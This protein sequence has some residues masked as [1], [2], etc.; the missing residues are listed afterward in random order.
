MF[1]PH[2][3]GACIEAALTRAE[4][5]CRT[6]GL[7]LTPLRRRVLEILLAGHRAMGAYAVLE[8]LG[9]DG[10]GAAQP[11]VAYRALDFLVAHGLA[12][13][14]E[15]LN[16]YVACSHGAAS[17]AGAAGGGTG[18]G[19]GRGGMAHA[20]V[21][22]ICQACGA[23]AETAWQPRRSVL[24]RAARAAGFRLEQVLSEALGTCPA[25]QEGG[26]GRAHGKAER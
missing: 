26:A 8:A 20:P 16:A 13:R 18:G 11:P 10:P 3:H 14:I 6:R 5:I 7:R 4:A 23:V 17:G 12:H 19:T 15:R 25:C 21:F 2:D 1:F 24:G 9:R 22:L